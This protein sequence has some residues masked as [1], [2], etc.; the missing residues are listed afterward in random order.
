MYIIANIPKPYHSLFP[1]LAISALCFLARLRMIQNKSDGHNVR[2]TMAALCGTGLATISSIQLTTHLK[3]FD[4]QTLLIIPLQFHF[5]NNSIPPTNHSLFPSL[6]ISALCFRA[7]LRMIQNNRHGHNVR[8]IMAALW[9]TGLATK[10]SIP[11]STHL[12]ICAA[13]YSGLMPEAVVLS[14][15]V[16][17]KKKIYCKGFNSEVLNRPSINK[18]ITQNFR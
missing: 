13:A 8:N 4:F 3:C 14:I 6:A 1:S 12:R 7:R 18:K 2:N 10:S 9:D 5:A 16:E 15:T 17:M 11:H